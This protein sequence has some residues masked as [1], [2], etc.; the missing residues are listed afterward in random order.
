MKHL[1]L[2]T[3]QRFKHGILLNTMKR[4]SRAMSESA[5]AS[6]GQQSLYMY[7]I[8]LASLILGNSKTHSVSLYSKR[9]CLKSTYQGDWT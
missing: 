1:Y 3:V 4:Q 5:I 9:S 7:H 6:A 2:I 8:G